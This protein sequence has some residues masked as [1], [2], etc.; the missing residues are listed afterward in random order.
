MSHDQRLHRARDLARTELLARRGDAVFWSGHLSSSALAVA[1]ALGALAQAGGSDD[2][3]RIQKGL[4]WL[5]THR[6]RDGGWGDTPGSPSNLPTT[7]LALAAFRL[8]HTALPTRA[9]ACAEALANHLP[10]AEALAKIYGKDRTFSVPIRMTCALAGSLRWEGIPDLPL[11]LA[12]L[13]RWLFPLLRLHVV[14]YALP[15]LIGVGLGVHA[16][17]PQGLRWRLRQWA[18]TRVLNRLICLQPEHGGF[19]DAIPLTSFVALGLVAAGHREHV[20]T[21]RCVEF[22]R[23]AQRADGS[24][25]IDSDL[26]VWVTSA[27]VQALASGDLPVAVKA[28]ALE[29]WLVARQQ[30]QTHPYTGAAP[31]GWAWTWR[32][33]GVPDAD[34]TAGALVALRH[35]R[36]TNAQADDPVRAGVQWLCT[37][38]NPDGG[39]PTFC[40]GWGHL[41][42]DRS[43]PDL[44]AHVLRALAAWPDADPRISRALKRGLKYLQKTQKTDGAWIPLWFGNQHATRQENPVL[45]TARVLRALALFDSCLAS[46]V[47]HPS[48][49]AADIAP[50]LN[51]ALT[52]L[53]SAQ[54]PTGGWGGA[55]NVVASV[56]ET[57][58]V[59]AG[60]HPWRNRS[61]VHTALRRAGDWLTARVEDGTWTTPVPIG[62][63]FAQLWYEEQLYPMVWTTEA[64]TLLAGDTA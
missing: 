50:T 33:G 19:L 57:A 47:W 44:T 41:P 37:L 27:A 52:F 42:F 8:A 18:T 14:S 40:R 2:A 6:N 51:R 59:I 3:P 15:A 21:S 5:S 54:L 45:G 61:D 4:A 13:P 29:S 30:R 25:P 64:L 26:S 56:E 9:E 60:L 32:A 49:L 48:A 12:L 7:L 28:S 17:A 16:H 46:G 1:T 11:E 24:W 36:G 62:L 35:L 43:A 23:S 10:F 20:V 31:G 58:L 34:D 55:T 38:Q 63:Y 53:L 39:W 22:L